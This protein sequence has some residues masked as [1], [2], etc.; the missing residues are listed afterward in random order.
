MIRLPQ[1]WIIVGLMLALPGLC[2]AQNWN[3]ILPSA[4]KI[5]DEWGD[6][7]S[8]FDLEAERPDDDVR[9]VLKRHYFRNGPEG[10]IIVQA[11][12]I[13]FKSVELARK[14]FDKLLQNKERI[15]PC[16]DMPEAVETLGLSFSERTVLFDR[17]W[18]RTQ[19]SGI[20]DDYQKV[21]PKLLEYARNPTPTYVFPTPSP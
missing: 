7:A 15:R 21:L 9:V 10:K 13:Q 8:S 14:R 5:G 20:G 19:Q 18:L 1:F 4:S 16:S 2:P 6:V 17:F 3:K 12:A 11:I